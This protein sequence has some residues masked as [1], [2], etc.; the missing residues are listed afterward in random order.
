MMKNNKS[1]SGEQTQELGMDIAGMV[2][3][4]KRTKAIVVALSGDLG[5][6]KTTF[7][8]GFL[9]GLGIRRRAVSPT[10]IIFRR[11]AIPSRAM[12][13]AVPEELRAENV[14][15]VDAY[16]LKKGKDLLDLG[17]DKILNDPKAIVLLEWPE[18]V[19]DILP[20]GMLRISFAHGKK[21][22]ERTIKIS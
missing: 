15:H 21:E 9:W 5:A 2:F 19:K 6:G 10:F 16:R 1:T 14:Y 3:K 18:K 8:Q 11:Y 17:F 4:K 13:G 12:K 20:Q 22:N 7:T